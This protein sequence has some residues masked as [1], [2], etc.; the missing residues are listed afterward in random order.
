MTRN[1]PT[2]SIFSCRSNAIMNNICF[3]RFS[4]WLHS[5]S[6][7]RIHVSHLLQNYQVQKWCLPSYSNETYRL[8]R[9]S[10]LPYLR[11]NTETSLG[12]WRSYAEMS[13]S[14][15]QG[16]SNPNTNQ[17]QSEYLIRFHSCS[18]KE[19]KASKSFELLVNLHFVFYNKK[20]T[21]L[22]NEL[23]KNMIYLEKNET[24]YRQFNKALVFHWYVRKSFLV[25]ITQVGQRYESICWQDGFP[26]ISFVQS[27]TEV[28]EWFSSPQFLPHGSLANKY[29]EQNDSS[30]AV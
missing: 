1:L 16:S 9:S 19:T 24:L 30:A 21:I 22:H 26:L 12:T 8:K 11:Q 23:H 3:A 5:R 29:E 10:W 7:W 14:I 17:S 28:S 18:E 25:G 2:L 13:W 4:S 20:R 27:R 6:W 15:C